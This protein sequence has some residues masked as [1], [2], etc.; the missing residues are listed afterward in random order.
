M[1]I[2]ISKAELSKLLHVTL[3]I[4]EKKSTMPILGNILLSA[5]DKSFKVTAS[6]LV[7]TAIA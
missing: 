7:I 1:E 3:A 5:E 2:T 4:A 6:D